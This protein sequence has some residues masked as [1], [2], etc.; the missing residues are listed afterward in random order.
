[1]RLCVY[2]LI[3]CRPFFKINPYN[4]IIRI[5]ADSIEI[6][7]CG[8][9]CF[10]AFC[11]S[12]T[13][14]TN[15]K[16]KIS[17]KD[18]TKKEN[19]RYQ[20][21]INRIILLMVVLITLGV[22]AEFFSQNGQDEFVAQ[23]FNNKHGGIFVDIG[24]SDGIT[25][26]NSYYFEKELGWQGI[27]VEPRPSSFAKLVKNRRCFCVNACIAQ[28]EGSRD[29]CEIEGYAGDLSGLI[30]SYHPSHVDRIESEIKKFGGY[31]KIYKVEC[32]P[33]AKLFGKY[34]IAAI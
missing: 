33:L 10:T 30:S 25:I 28:E 34:R 32:L 5:H 29:F 23:W 11:D 19:E 4:F 21:M 13:V 9:S 1:M 16:L 8:N 20:S 22:D 31:K 15:S 27:C 2:F 17:S 26:N 6:Y 24:A 18:I 14:L 12:V 3:F 7:I